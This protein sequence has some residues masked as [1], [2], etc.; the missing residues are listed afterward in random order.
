MYRVKSGKHVSQL[1]VQC[2]DFYYLAMQVYQGEKIKPRKGSQDVW[3][4][5]FKKKTK[6]K[7][8]PTNLL[9][10]SRLSGPVS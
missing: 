2:H 6:Q 8:E 5:Y 4:S 10:Y 3:A 1:R 9:Q 7:Q